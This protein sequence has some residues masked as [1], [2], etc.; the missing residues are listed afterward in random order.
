MRIPLCAALAVLLSA[1]AT[2]DAHSRSSTAIANV[3]RGNPLRAVLLNA[4]RPVI[5]KD[6]RQPVQF[7]VKKLRTDGRWAFAVVELRTPAGGEINYWKM[8]YKDLLDAGAFDGGACYALLRREKSGWRVKA[9]SIGATDVQ[10][11]S[12]PEEFGVPRELLVN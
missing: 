5:A 12:W 7:V 8:H 11:D 10:W 1:T 2:P 6:L 3:A 4:L 9:F